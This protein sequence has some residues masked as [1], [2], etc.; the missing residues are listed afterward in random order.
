MITIESLFK[1]Y[2][3]KKILKDIN[4]SFEKGRVIGI[5]GEN[6]A[7]K[8]TLFKCIAGMENYDGKIIYENVLKN[9]IGFVSTDPYFLSKITGLEYLQFVCNARDM[10]MQNIETKNIFDLPLNQFADTYSTG[11]KKKLALTGVLLQKNEVFILDEPFN[12]VDIQ[13]NM[14]INEVILKL[15]KMNKIII[16]SSHIFST[17][18]EICDNLHYL[19]NGEI[20]KSV[21][22]NE[23]DSVENEMKNIGIKSKIDQLD[24]ILS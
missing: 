20:K 2:G 11:M 3:S 8:T 10:E 4:L 14:I 1:S 24:L 9:H 23:F 15:K 13:S 21:D 18:R 6:G 5:V 19:D 12:G 17:L 22:K 7:G 16:L